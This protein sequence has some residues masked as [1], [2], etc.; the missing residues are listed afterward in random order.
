MPTNKTKP[1]RCCKCGIV[2]QCATPDG[3]DPLEFMLRHPGLA[4]G[5]E[6]ALCDACN[7]D[8]EK[9]WLELSDERR[10]TILAEALKIAHDHGAV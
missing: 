8:F 2:F 1:Y 7:A 6:E 9:W 4:L 3:K 10:S 5:D